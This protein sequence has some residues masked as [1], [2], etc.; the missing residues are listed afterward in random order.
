[1][2]EKIKNI[3]T[4]IFN[5]DNKFNTIL[6]VFLIILFFILNFKNNDNSKINKTEI[7]DNDVHIFVQESCKHCYELKKFVKEENLEKKYKI[8]FHDLSDKKSFD[9]LV[10][11]TYI[12]KISLSKI[13]TPAIFTKNK[14]LIGFENT[15]EGKEKVSHLLNNALNTK[16]E[17]NNYKKILKIPFVGEV[18]LFDLSLPILTILVGLADGF[19]PC[20]MWVLVYLLS[21]TV[22]LGDR[23][24]IWLLVGSFVL[25]SGILYFLFMTAWLNAFL[26]IG[27]IRLLNLIIGLFALYFGITTINEYIKNKGQINCKLE[28]NKTRNKSMNKIKNI[29]NAKLSTFTILSIVFLAFVVNSI[30]FVCSAALPATYTYLL[31]QAHLNIF[32]YYM[33]ILLYT[34]MFMLDDI[35]VFSCAVFAMNKYIGSKYEKYSTIIGGSIMLIIGIFIV[36]FPELLK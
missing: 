1:M 8:N 4:Y 12:H 36:F 33:Y 35:I 21:I 7:I 18:N 34:I 25:S 5:K 17:E 31:T 22:T 16:N 14:Y 29:V 2:L 26:F 28:N 20:A 11:Y 30:E 23:K 3:Y 10:K 19:N 27:Y 6:I 9:L 24:K 32:I 13:G 15:Q